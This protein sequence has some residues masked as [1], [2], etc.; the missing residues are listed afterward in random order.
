MKPKS[1]T[2]RR[3]QL[4]TLI[5]LA[6]AG[7]ALIQPAAQSATLYWDTNGSTTSPTFGGATGTWGVDS[8]WTTS[9][10]GSFADN[11][12]VTT[13]ADTLTVSP[14]AIS[15]LTVFGAVSC[16]SIDLTN[17]GGNP[18]L[19]VSGGTSITLGTG[20]S[21][22]AGI[23]TTGDGSAAVSTP[24][25]LG[26]SQVFLNQTG[27]GQGSLT[28]SGGITGT[29]ALSLQGIKTLTISGGALNNTGTVTNT[30]TALTTISANIGAAVTSVT[31]NSTNTMILSGTN[32]GF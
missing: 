11:R 9:S 12:I 1:I 6:F 2:V 16:D 14:N 8:F 20:T 4:L 18:L 7:A 26:S 17:S 23:K 13:T 15:T 22:T 19:T 30:N 29:S 32:S 28:I 25:I 3:H 31:Q 10:N 24:L 27:N 21:V 5:A